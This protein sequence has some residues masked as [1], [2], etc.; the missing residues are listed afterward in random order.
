MA[1]TLPAGIRGTATI[2]NT[3]TAVSEAA[4]PRA[5]T[6][7]PLATDTS[8]PVLTAASM[9]KAVAR[10]CNASLVAIAHTPVGQGET[11]KNRH[12]DTSEY[13]PVADIVQTRR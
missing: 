10:H 5:P 3:V 8:L 11:V 1:P 2:P 13:H 6:L 9:S 7:A 4:I 12:L